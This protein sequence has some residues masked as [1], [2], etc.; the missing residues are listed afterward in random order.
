MKRSIYIFLLVVF[1]TLLTAQEMLSLVNSNYAGS[2]GISLN[3][4]STAN[5]KLKFDINIG[6]AH[7][8]EQN[9]YF[10]LPNNEAGAF[11]LMTGSYEFPLRPKPFGPG[12]RNVQAY[13]KDHRPKNV[14]LNLRITGPS[15]MFSYRDNVF[16]IH[17]AFRT[18]ASTRNVPYDMANFSYY[19]L[20]YYPQHNIFYIRDDYRTA[21]MAFWELGFSYATIIKRDVRNLWSAGISYNRLFGYSGA[22]LSGGSTSYIAYNDSILSAVN[23]NA[24]FGMAL[25]VNYENDEV[26]FS[27][28]IFKGSGAGIDIG[29]TYQFREAAYQRKPMPAFYK[30]HFEDYKFKLGVSVLDIGRILFKKNAQVHAYE[31][32]SN[33]WINVDQMDYENIQEEIDEL[34]NMFYGDPKGSYRGDQFKIYLPMTLSVQADYNIRDSWYVNS[35]LLLPLRVFNPM[36]ERPMILALTPRYECRA[37]GVSMPLVLY[38]YTQ[39]RLGFALRIFDLT[40]GSDNLGGFFGKRNFTGM[41]LYVSLKIN[42]YE[43]RKRFFDRRNPCSYN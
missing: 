32:V 11:K 41:D 17:T 7:F 23:F 9:N 26:D 20:D 42:I 19:T 35:T 15:A 30:K 13:D 38:D 39:P 33:T 21:S 14:Y 27:H 24:E 25:P 5:T 1:P 28:D 40:V 29:F 36:V 18:I 12:N 34:S 31:N 3:P 10:Y 37:F 6:T 43:K 16:T 4:S 22:Y 2:S 8:F